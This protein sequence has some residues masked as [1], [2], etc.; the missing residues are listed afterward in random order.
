MRLGIDATPLLGHRTGIGTYVAHLL[1]ELAAA[2]DKALT[3]TATAF[4][5]AG[6]AGI[7]NQLPAG[8]RARAARIPARVLQ[9]SWRLTNWP[10]IELLCGQQDV[11]HATNF[12]L[13]PAR[14]AQGVVSVHDLSFVR[15][16]DTVTANTL[17]YRSLVPTSLRRAAVV[18]TLSNA[19]AEEIA[20]EY[21]VE[22]SR[23]IVASPGVDQAWFTAK[24]LDPVARGELGLPEDY[25]L[26][27]GTLEP[28]KNLPTLI[29]AYRRLRAEISDAPPLVL[30]GPAGWGPQLQLGSLPPGSVRLTGYLDEPVLRQVV[31]GARCL[32][33]PSMYEGFGLP[34]VEA[35]ACGIPVV[36]SDLPVTREALAD[37]ADFV[38]PTDAD[39]WT[40]ALRRSLDDR[41]DSQRAKRIEQARRWTW[42]S[43]ADQIR[44]AYDAALG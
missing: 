29:E 19:V 4:S 18:T 37:A 8:I 14:R 22:R 41:D 12:V 2:D 38:V 20:A 9:Q 30:V 6:P 36:A 40:A 24:P 21:G 34:P 31:A 44:R 23:I 1:R 25:L 3:I 7:R 5:S 10:P 39:A 33:F 42:R 32:A 35:L 13:P 17:R 26:A 43:C 11:F 27:V 15:Y 28:R 16:P